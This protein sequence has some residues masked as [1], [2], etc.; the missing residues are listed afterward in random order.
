M[1]F[2]TAHQEKRYY[3]RAATEEEFLEWYHKQD[4]GTYEKPSVTVDN[5]IFGW[6]GQLKLLFIQRKS[7]PCINQ[8]AFPGGFVKK[9][10][11]PDES[12]I[13][14]ASEETGLELELRHMK[15][16]KTIGTP[17][18]DP[19]TWIITIAYLVFLPTMEGIALQAGGD[20]QD[21]KWL[22]VQVNP[23]GS[24][25]LQEGSVNI[26]PTQLAFDHREILEA[27]MKQIKGNFQKA[28]GIQQILGSSPSQ[29]QTN[30]LAKMLSI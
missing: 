4:L 19:R 27:A 13:R 29:S 21:A 16:F 12:A 6:D 9:E 20:A 3:E 28:D 11:S 2:E 10:E 1:I 14:E 18:R 23:D 24:L 30:Q 7:H 26:P 17:N 22:T 15:Q 8:Y 25:L 5:L